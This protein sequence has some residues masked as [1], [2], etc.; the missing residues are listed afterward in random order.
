MS[1]PNGQI[2]SE[3]KVQVKI[4]ASADASLGGHALT[5]ALFEAIQQNDLVTDRTKGIAVTQIYY[6]VISD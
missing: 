2:K 1:E 6:L 5:F 4:E 3:P